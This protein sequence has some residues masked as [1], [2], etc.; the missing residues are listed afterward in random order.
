MILPLG[1]RFEQVLTQ[2]DRQAGKAQVMAICRCSFVP[3]HGKEGWA[4]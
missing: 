1:E 2:V 3:L 4:E